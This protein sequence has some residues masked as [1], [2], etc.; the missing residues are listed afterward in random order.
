[1]MIQDKPERV[2]AAAAAETQRGQ[3]RPAPKRRRMRLL[4][5]L[6]AA[7]IG[8]ALAL[9]T[10]APESQRTEPGSAEAAADGAQVA[11]APPAK[12]EP[13]GDPRQLDLSERL[14]YLVLAAEMA[15]H[16]EDLATAAGIYAQALDEAEDIEDAWLSNRV[17]Q[18]AFLARNWPLTLSASLASLRRDIDNSAAAARGALAAVNSGNFKVA[19]G[20]I[21]GR[22][23]PC[24][25]DDALAEARCTQKKTEPLWTQL[26]ALFVRDQ[27]LAFCRAP[28]AESRRDLAFLALCSDSALK[29]GDRAAAIEFAQ[30]MLAVYDENIKARMLLAEAAIG[31]EHEE[32]AFDGLRRLIERLNVDLGQD[33]GALKL[34]ADLLILAGR[35]GEI[36]PLISHLR[37]R[38]GPPDQL[39]Y[40]GL[41]LWQ[42]GARGEARRWLSYFAGQKAPVQ[43]LAHHYLGLMA[44]ERQDYEA[45]LKHYRRVAGGKRHHESVRRSAS[46]QAL[47]GDLEAALDTLARSRTGLDKGEFE[48]R[49]RSWLTES[50]LLREARSLERAAESLG[51]GLEELRDQPQSQ[52]HLFYARG[53]ILRQL[54]R[55]AAFISDMESALAINPNFPPALNALAYYWIE[56]DI[57]FDRARTYLDRALKFDPDNS[58]I[59]DS[60]GWLEFK[61]R[62][63]ELAL[64]HLRQALKH[65]FHP[66][67]A[68]H[69]IETL[70][71]LGH[72]EEA[73]SL[74]QRAQERFPDDPLLKL[75]IAKLK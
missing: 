60:Y 42:Q 70:W 36:G 27:L 9:L 73:T 64:Q 52:I 14:F 63:Y 35:H 53:L 16:Q 59:I 44:E 43:W 3:P 49:M 68:A 22:Q 10:S 48:P 20:L 46:V 1:M 11:E 74:L 15:L 12:S 38:S 61:E 7:V 6:L 30:A 51:R 26:H 66:E 18:V 24:K 56:E 57:H 58:A 13:A 40:P 23:P 75:V 32:E 67:I 37:G 39:L 31:S 5:L 69:L 71:V 41:K 19:S 55:V 25:S 2:S 33:L 28:P 47:G 50:R 21:W 29:G 65:S 34:Y 17:A 8:G 54:E 72:R 45:A 62:N 4:L